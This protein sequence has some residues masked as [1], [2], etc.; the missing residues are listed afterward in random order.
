[1]ATTSHFAVP[2]AVTDGRVA[3]VEQ[4]TIEDV[5]QSV[6]VLLATEQGTYQ[7]LP[8]LGLADPTFRLG[9]VDLD[10]LAA[11]VEEWEPRAESLT[12]AQ[13]EGLLQKVKVR[14]GV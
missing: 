14:V 11:V 2:F 8:E 6:F 1:M 4:D 7:P 12:E 9:G 10:E 13:W 3:V 5:T